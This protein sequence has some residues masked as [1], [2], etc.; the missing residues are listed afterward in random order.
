MATI[1]NETVTREGICP[2]HGR[3]IAE[4]QMPKL[5]FPFVVTAVARGVAA[6]RPYRCPDCGAK[7]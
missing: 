6:M 5:K 3:V 2:T 4:K 7:A 1:E